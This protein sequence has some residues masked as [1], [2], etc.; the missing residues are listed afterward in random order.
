MADFNLDLRA[1]E[2]HLDEEDEESGQVTLAVLDG[3]TPDEEWIDAVERGEVLVLA[4]EGDLNVLA[5]GFA[6]EIREM[7]GD[8]V[9]FREFLIVTPPGTAVS[10]DR[11]SSN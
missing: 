8:L 1:V 7:G 4:I 2:D 6:R 3:T 5:A 11:L 9:H 10:T